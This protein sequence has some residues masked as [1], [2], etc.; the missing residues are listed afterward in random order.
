MNNYY[1]NLKTDYR[2]DYLMKIPTKKGALENAALEGKVTILSGSN[3]RAVIIET[4]EAIYLQSYDTLICKIDKKKRTL[5]K[6]WH[7]Y[8]VTTMKHINEFLYENGF[9]KMS[10]REWLA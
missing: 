7:D 1:E 3:N 5:E 8:S 6:L 2:H 9:Q 10:K 4:E